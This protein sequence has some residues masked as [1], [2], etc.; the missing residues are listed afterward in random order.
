V[1]KGHEQPVDLEDWSAHK[2][3]TRDRLAPGEQVA[4]D[5]PMRLIQAGEYRVVVGA[6]SRNGGALTPSQFVDFSV[7]PKPVVESARVL[8]VAFGVP[9]LLLAFMLFGRWRNPK[10]DTAK[11]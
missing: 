10:K 3:V 6:L 8:P 1:D 11:G 4:T 7:D 9:G 2:A 5:W